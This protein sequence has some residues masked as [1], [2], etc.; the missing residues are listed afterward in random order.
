MLISLLGHKLLVGVCSNGIAIFPASSFDAPPPVDVNMQIYS[1]IS[2][3]TYLY[4]YFLRKHPKPLLD[5][6]SP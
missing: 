1:S 4:S 2:Y 6:T 3:I 5:P